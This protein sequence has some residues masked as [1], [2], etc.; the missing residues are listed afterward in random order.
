M[1]EKLPVSSHTIIDQLEELDVSRHEDLCTQLVET[2]KLAPEIFTLEIVDYYFHLL[3]ARES[4]FRPVGLETLLLLKADP[5]R[6]ARCA[7]IAMRDF[8]AVE[9]A[10][11]IIC[12]HIANV[13]SSLIKNSFRSLSLLAAPSNLPFTGVER[14]A[15]PEPLLALHRHYP[16]AVKAAIQASL[17]SK[18]YSAIETATEAILIIEQQDKS[19]ATSFSRS[20][21]ALLARPE[22]LID[23]DEHHSHYDESNLFHD[24]QKALKSSLKAAPEL[25]DELVSSFLTTADSEATVRL[26][27]VYES[28]FHSDAWL[29]GIKETEAHSIALR[30]LV[31]TATSMVKFDDLWELLGMF[32][33]GSPKGLDNLICKEAT[34][35][36]GAAFLLENQRIKIL[37]EHEQMKEFWA[38]VSHDN[39]YSF[40]VQLQKGLVDWVAGTAAGSQ[41][42]ATVYL[43]T[44]SGTPENSHHLRGIMIK[45]LSHFMG[46]VEGLNL[47]L[48]SLYSA[49]VGSSQQERASAIKALK[50]LDSARRNDLPRLLFE[51]FLTTLYDPYLIVHQSAVRALERFSLPEEFTPALKQ[52]VKSLIIHYS[53]GND[54]DEFLAE[55]IYLY[56]SRYADKEELEGDVGA[57]M[58]SQLF[59]MKPKIVMRNHFEWHAKKLKRSQGIGDLAVK[60]LRASSSDYEV[61]PIFRV[62]RD[63]PSTTVYAE[64]KA[65]ERVAMER[66]DDINFIGSLIELL[67]RSGA[68]SESERIAKAV[69][70]ATPNTTWDFQRRQFANL[71]YIATKLESAIAG[72]RQ[73]ET[74]EQLSQQW[75]ETIEHIE[76]DRKKY[77][78]RRDPLRGLFGQNQGD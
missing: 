71:L 72:I 6:L 35:L 78:T 66:L 41:Q 64:R 54:D 30:R 14:A 60:L 11:K 68:L 61:E 42:T 18:N 55:C 45:A 27:S 24:L 74:V 25:T 49:L 15:M 37:D 33:S 51:I 62:F 1:K 56:V 23:F 17:D 26:L 2:A 59:R 69:V 4:W 28:L 73:D 16:D 39:Q 75:L 3:E 46:T 65:L 10:C 38:S 22:L 77:E 7:L 29:E 8:D 57:L 5:V 63:L 67:T 34:F 53:H 50:E 47:A 52:L 40:L 70:E 44:L 43:E 12:E 20:I 36:L 76:Q 19:I 58:V 48:P 32:R 31:N 21:I 9:I 13:D